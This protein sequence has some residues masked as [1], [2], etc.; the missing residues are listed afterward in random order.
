VRDC[1]ATSRA[2]GY[3]VRVEDQNAFKMR[4]QNEVVLAG[5][6]DLVIERDREV[7]II[8]CKTGSPQVSDHMQVLI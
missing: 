3:D 8:D 7:Y 1:A 2:K 5:K 6:P 4:G